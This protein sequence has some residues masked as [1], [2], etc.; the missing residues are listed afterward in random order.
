MG[1]GGK[2][3]AGVGIA[4]CVARLTCVLSHMSHL[5][6]QLVSLFRAINS[7]DEFQNT[8]MMIGY[9]ISAWLG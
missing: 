2:K 7:K 5:F 3:M 1:L 4:L 8:H 6:R 9:W